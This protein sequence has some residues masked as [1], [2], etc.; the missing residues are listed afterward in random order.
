MTHPVYLYIYIKVAQKTQNGKCLAPQV[1]PVPNDTLSLLKKN[2]ADLTI[3]RGPK[4]W[5]LFVIVDKKYVNMN[6]EH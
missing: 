1:P 4:F 6:I 5:R 3:F 2:E